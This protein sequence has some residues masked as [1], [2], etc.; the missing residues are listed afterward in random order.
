MITNQLLNGVITT[1]DRARYYSF[2][3]WCL[4]HIAQHERP[5]R[6]P[7]FV[8][9]F[10]RRESAMVIATLLNDPEASVIGKL[11]HA[12]VQAMVTGA[13]ATVET[14]F[15]C[16]PASRMGGYGQYY[17]GCI[18]DLALRETTEE[19]IDSGLRWGGD[20]IGR[21]VPLDRRGHAL[22]QEC[23]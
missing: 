2:Y 11:G 20:S 1:T 7:A 5:S 17:R 9:A 13:K 4:W 12:S 18:Y 15:R 14:Q 16:L 19:G 8:E 3:I 6:G 21:G 23:A 22:H 10:Q